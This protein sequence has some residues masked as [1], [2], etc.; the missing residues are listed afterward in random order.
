MALDLRRWVAGALAACVVVAIAALPGGGTVTIPS[1]A[2]PHSPGTRWGEEALRL[3]ACVAGLRGG[4][5]K[6]RPTGTSSR[7]R[8]TVLAPAGGTAPLLL[9]DG[10]STATQ[11]AELQGYLAEMWGKAAPEGFKVAVALVIERDSVPPLHDAPS[12][13]RGLSSQYVFPDSL[14][15]DLCLV[16]VRDPNNAG[17]FF[18]P[19]RTRPLGL[20]NE[21]HWLAQALGPCA[22][23][24]A[25]GIPGREVGRWV[26]GDGYQ[27]AMYPRWWLSTDAYYGICGTRRFRSRGNPPSGGAT[28]TAPCHGKG[29]PATRAG[30]VAAR[31]PSM[32]VPASPTVSPAAGARISGGGSR[33]C[34]G[35]RIISPTWPGPSAP[36]AFPSSGPPTF[37][38]T[39][40]YTWPAENR[41][42]SG[43]MIGPAGAACA[44]ILAPRHHP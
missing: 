37:P 40:P 19:R 43:P 31:R 41:S 20:D 34:S 44:S 1:E 36:T 4:G 9:V 5:F 13:P 32:T 23:Y 2:P 39:A 38:W 6:L 24:G 28:C 8:R 7:S 12:L 17:R 30:P 14:H 29:L 15:R 25:Y 3:R 35:A 21:F 10:P 42:T 11:R 26:A 18:D 27:F 33:H 22:F 16:V